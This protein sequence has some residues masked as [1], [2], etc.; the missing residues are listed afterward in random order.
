MPTLW[1]VVPAHGRLQ[2][3]AICLR[4]LRR[5][6]DALS[7]HGIEATAV[8]VGDD[9]NLVTA[10]ELGFGTI[11][12][13]NEFL[14][15]KYNDGI[16]L[17]CDPEYNPRSADYVMP[18]GTDDWIDHRILLELPP[19]DTILAF[20]TIALV[21]E[22][23]R[24]MTA[25]VLDNA[26]GAGLR[27]YPRAIMAQAG[28]RPADEDRN[29]GCDTSKI[30]YLKKVAR[31]RIHY[32]QIDPRQIVDWKSATHQV[33]AYRSVAWRPARRWDDP[34]AAL[35]DFYSPAALEE[36]RGLR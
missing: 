36:M 2:L 26:G 30:L 7:E 18:Y 35:A 13:S 32:R 23:A 21:R 11:R 17:A 20:N 33:N 24:E 1:F 14:G 8:V 6:C 22:D 10:R 19:P 5:T 4:Q 34:F 3:A 16:Q 25:R 12:R 28:Y 27:V 29:R 15:R 9:E 31:F